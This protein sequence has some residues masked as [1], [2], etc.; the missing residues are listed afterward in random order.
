M[1][2]Y[3]NI[4]NDSFL[5]NI[6]LKDDES[7]VNI[8]TF[9]YKQDK[10][11]IDDIINKSS[12][13]FLNEKEIDILKTF[14]KSLHNY[15][16]EI[17]IKY[18]KDK[19]T[20]LL[21][22]SNEEIIAYCLKNK[23]GGLIDVDVLTYDGIKYLYFSQGKNNISNS[24]L[25]KDTNFI[26]TYKN[27]IKVILT[28]YIDIN[29]IIV[30]EIIRFEVEF[31]KNKMSNSER[32]DIKSIF[33]KY[34]ISDIKFNNI[35]YSKLINILLNKDI[36]LTTSIYFDTKLPNNYYNLLDN[37]FTDKNFKYYIIWS[38]IL[39]LSYISIGSLYDNVFELIKIIKGIK[40]K[41]NFDKKTY[42]LN[43]QLIGHLISKEYFINID[44]SIKDQI[45]QYIVYIKRSF[46]ERLINN[47]WMDQIT[48]ETAIKKLDKIKENIYDGKLI[49]FNTMDKLTNIYSE[50]FHIINEYIFKK[51]IDELYM[52]DRYFYGNTYNINAFYETTTNQIIFPH[53]ILKPPYYYNTDINNI[54]NLDNIAYNF[55]A[56]GSVIGHEIIHGF[57]DQ[58]RLFDEK[59][60]LKNWWQP[61]SEKKYI[62][63]TKKIG[64]LYESHNINSELTMGENIADIGGVRI[65]LSAYKIFLK[66]KNKKL[67]DNLLSN[68]LKGWAM[69]WRGKSRKEEAANRLLND[70]HSPARQRVNIP[71][72]NL[73]ETYKND[74]KKVDSIIEIW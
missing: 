7:I 62:E 52:N 54:K 36:E 41:M 43:S 22:L 15:N 33:N 46:Q 19:I 42:G 58:G 53:G 69:V 14:N 74:L 9:R 13:K 24:D 23:V 34:L 6:Q 45:K 11:L 12:Y 44:P 37:F 68:F 17:N 35:S 16:D 18:I 56:I 73:I 51:K 57:D 32:R 8:G 2:D 29:D 38:I 50:N 65:A 40:K 27:I 64:K 66:E 59:G 60:Y 21:T 61:E 71:F 67:D 63:L 3:Y 31:E 4:I 10:I 20:K 28:P 1:K 39:E 55:G 70:P 25:Y 26:K 48:K 49:D 30:D 5:K 47:K 72:N